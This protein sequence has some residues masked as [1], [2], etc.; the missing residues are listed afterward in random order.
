MPNL[1]KLVIA[2]LEEFERIQTSPSLLTEED[3][4]F[5]PGL[6]P[7][8]EGKVFQTSRKMEQDIALIAKQLRGPDQSLALKVTNEEWRKMMRAEIGPALAKIDF[9][10]PADSNADQVISELRNAIEKHR[11]S[12]SEREY[13]F[14]C[15]LFSN[16]NIKTFQ[17]GPVR[18]EPRLDWLQ[19]TCAEGKITGISERRIR[20]RWTGAKLRKRK[21]SWESHQESGILDAL[22]G[23]AFVCS[24]ET[25][26]FASEAGR[27]KALL[28]ARMAQTSV[29]LLWPT[30]S[31]A[32]D[33]MNLKYDRQ[34]YNKYTLSF[35]ENRY[36]LAGSKSSQQP[37]GPYLKD[38]LWDQIF[39]E[40]KEYFEL[41]A[42]ILDFVTAPEIKSGTRALESTL[43]Q[44]LF[45][46][47]EACREQSNFVSIVKF[48][49]SLDA[50][51]CGGKEK[52][53]QRLICARLGLEPDSPIRPKGPS[54]RE[55][56]R[57]VYN[58]GRSRAVH[59]TSEKI[60]HDCSETRALAERFA[61]LCL[62]ECIRHAA[63][64]KNLTDP[65][66]FSLH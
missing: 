51:A 22:E 28:A 54:L 39:S 11:T 42:K 1:K 3:T 44:S 7:A 32:L 35:T 57:K 18:F 46:F 4:T 38:G 34:M 53:I 30:P 63:L 58:E 27:E 43:S 40:L 24:V 36:T 2:I 12:F 13:V 33:G 20:K 5:F 29:A 52:G 45:W 6:I 23:C 26:G 9:D 59:G 17:I 19:R 16:E 62:V 60:Y 48:S 56:L 14:G 10:R 55:A 47:H 31:G 65:N 64:E 21:P 8:G 50:L 25:N 37:F 15:S 49:A 66:K 41:V 61:Q